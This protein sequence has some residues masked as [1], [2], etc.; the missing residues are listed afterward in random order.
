MIFK[1]LPLNFLKEPVSLLKA[2][3]QNFYLKYTKLFKPQLGSNWDK[4]FAIYGHTF[5]ASMS[6]A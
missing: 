6:Y 4:K 2:I 3:L 1:V 5:I